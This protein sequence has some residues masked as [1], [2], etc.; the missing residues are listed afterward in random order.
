MPKYLY[1]RPQFIKLSIK[2][3]VVAWAESIKS[4]FIVKRAEL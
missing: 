4:T 2:L 1:N 3:A